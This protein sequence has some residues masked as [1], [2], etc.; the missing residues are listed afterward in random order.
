M[1]HAESLKIRHPEAGKG[2][3]FTSPAPF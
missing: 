1:L 2:M 3:T